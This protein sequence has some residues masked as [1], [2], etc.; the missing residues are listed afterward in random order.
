MNEYF[1]ILRFF[2]HGDSV[3]IGI[4]RLPSYEDAKKRAFDT[5]MRPKGFD[6]LKEDFRLVKIIT[7]LS[8]SEVADRITKYVN[9]NDARMDGINYPCFNIV[10]E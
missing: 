7:D 8:F 5:L 10:Y 9:L 3:H 4:E 2:R 6:P 1:G